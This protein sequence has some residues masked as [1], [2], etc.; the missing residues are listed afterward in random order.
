MFAAGIEPFVG[1]LYLA[2]DGVPPP[3]RLV[4]DRAATAWAE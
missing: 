4:R 3:L 1:D 2:V